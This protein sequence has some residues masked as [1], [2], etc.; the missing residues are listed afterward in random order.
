[1]AQVIVCCCVLDKDS[2]IEII[3]WPKNEQEKTPSGE[4]CNV[5]Y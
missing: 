1:L 2:A 3:Y 4:V 5:P